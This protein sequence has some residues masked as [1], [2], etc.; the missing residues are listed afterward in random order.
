MHEASRRA[1]LSRMSTTSPT[2]REPRKEFDLERY[3]GAYDAARRAVR[4]QR[5]VLTLPE[6]M[7][8]VR[9]IFEAWGV[10]A[11]ASSQARALARMSLDPLW[12]WKHPITAHR[13]GWR[14]RF[15]PSKDD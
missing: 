15:L 13:E 3:V 9:T 7:G 6:A 10:P 12:G 2:P 4:E 14:F 5:K 11:P 8:L 1:T